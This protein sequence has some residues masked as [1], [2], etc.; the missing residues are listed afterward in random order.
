MVVRVKGTAPA[1][2]VG[3]LAAPVHLGRDLHGT[4]DANL[5]ELLG[6]GLGDVQPDLIPGPH[7]ED[8]AN[9][10]AVP[11]IEALAVQGASGVLQ[12]LP[13][14]GGVAVPALHV[15]QVVE[16]ALEGAVGRDAPA[17][18]HR[19]H[20]GLPVNGAAHGGNQIPV[21]RPIGVLEVEEDAPVVRSLHLVD[22]EALFSLE[23]G[24]V[25]GGQQR[26]IQLPGLHLHRLGVVVG[27]NLED[28]R[29]DVGG[30]LEV[31]LVPGEGD[32]LPLVP[33][34]QLIGAGTHRGAEEGGLLEVLP[35]QQVP[36]QHGHGHIV[37]KG[38][39]GGR[40]PEG[41]GVIVHHR[42]LLHV[43]IV[44]GVLRAV[45]RVHDGLDG[46][47]HVPGGEGLAVVPLHPLLQVEGVGAGALI[48][49][50]ASGQGRDHLVFAVVG[51]EAVEQENVDLPV[52]VHGRVDAGIVAA[53]VDQGGASGGGSGAVRGGIRIAAAGGQRQ[54]KSQQQREKRLFH[55]VFLLGTRKV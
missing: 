38:R 3:H 39:V 24:R 11:L 2:E 55:V 53:A 28:D 22:G 54:H 42:D 8:E 34:G 37:Q 31:V 9:L 21:L 20:D 51:G 27:D 49:L 45:V 6:G 10:L 17:Q 35:L 52:L 29:L 14:T 1:D 33:G 4:A 25:L 48:K 46:E 23:I 26:Q 43:L 19:V 30:A 7:A 47:L 15:L 5:L 16:V 40:E 41:D 12:D 18:E 13:G 44:G 36:G 32:G 50:P